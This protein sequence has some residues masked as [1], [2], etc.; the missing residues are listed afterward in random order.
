MG[1]STN[2]RRSTRDSRLSLQERYR[3]HAGYVVKV[4]LA[5]AKLVKDR[6]LLPEDVL[7]YT[8]EAALSR[9]GR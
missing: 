9:V 4:T 6:L 8:A 1:L 7:R 5:A 2:E 3:T